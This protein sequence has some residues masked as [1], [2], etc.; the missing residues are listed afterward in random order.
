ML[1][2]ALNDCMS[3]GR[4]GS[5]IDAELFVTGIWLGNAAVSQQSWETS[6]YLAA[7]PLSPRAARGA[8]I[9]AGVVIVTLVL[10]GVLL[11]QLSGA[12]QSLARLLVTM[13][14][15]SEEVAMFKTSPITL[16]R[17]ALPFLGFSFAIWVGLL[18]HTLSHYQAEIRVAVMIAATCASPYLVLGCEELKSWSTPMRARLP[19][20]QWLPGIVVGVIAFAFAC[21]SHLRIA[22]RGLD[23]LI[24][25]RAA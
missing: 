14:G 6:E 5:I 3:G 1:L 24:A 25:K 13:R 4:L 11:F 21:N 18:L 7:L 8:A 22:R 12:A 15:A 10:A 16:E 2:T 19:M 9:D 20:A 17:A 23:E